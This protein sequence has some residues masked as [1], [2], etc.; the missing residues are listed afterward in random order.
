MDFVRQFRILKYLIICLSCCFMADKADDLLYHEAEYLP[1]GSSVSEV[2]PVEN[3]FNDA[4]NYSFTAPETQC[5]I[6]RQTSISNTLRTFAQAKRPNH[7]NSTR[8]GFTM[9]KPG[10]SMN[11]YTTSLFLVSILNFP[12]GLSERTHRLI[13]L[14][15]LI[16]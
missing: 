13:S 3:R 9:T 2:L 8:H 15:K 7:L 11:P 10:K 6:P 1:S 12:S 4:D 16:I 14:G 5:R